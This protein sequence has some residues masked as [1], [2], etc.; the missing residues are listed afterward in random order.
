MQMDANECEVETQSPV[1]QKCQEF[2][3]SDSRALNPA[4]G[5]S[6]RRDLGNGPGCMPMEPAL[7]LDPEEEFT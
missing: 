1:F 5:R 7:V 6:E 2:R 3:D 4:Q